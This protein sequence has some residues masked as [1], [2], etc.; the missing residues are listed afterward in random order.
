M[1]VYSRLDLPDNNR[2]IKSKGFRADEAAAAAVEE[3]EPSSSSSLLWYC[4]QYKHM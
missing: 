3:P 2:A 4:D 1:V